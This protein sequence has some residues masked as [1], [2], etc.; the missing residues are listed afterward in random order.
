MSIVKALNGLVKTE[1]EAGCDFFLLI[2]G[3]FD[4][5]THALVKVM[6]QRYS[7]ATQ[8]FRVTTVQKTVQRGQFLTVQNIGRSRVAV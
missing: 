2:H 7:I 1:A 5:T 3:E 6:E 4:D 8:E